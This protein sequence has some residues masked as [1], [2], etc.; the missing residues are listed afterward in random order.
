M[1]FVIREDMKRH[2]L[3]QFLALAALIS[4]LAASEAPTPL[5]RVHAHNDYMHTRPLLDA[6]DHG[7]CSVE[8]DIYLVDG[9]L[10]VAHDRNK[11]DPQRTLQSLYLEPL[12]QRIKANGGRLYRNGPPSWLLI[13]VKSDAEPTFAALHEVLRSYADILTEFRQ[14]E[15]KTNA[16]TVVISGNRSRPAL[17]AQAVRYATYDGRLADL[18]A[19]EP[20]D[21]IPWISDNWAL[22]FKWRG[23]GPISTAEQAKLHDIL[24]QAHRKG[25]L[26]RFWGAPDRAEVWEAFY[27]A[28]VDLLNTDDLGGMQKFLLE[29][30][31]KN[32]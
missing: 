5:T 27:A 28:G 18:S 6:L 23:Q 1:K 11:V 14:G 4:T 26:V 32:P 8:A 13:D 17:A 22:F 7:F 25:R 19:P 12:R 31:N 10:L 3:I 21:F 2:Y 15:V 30:G 16:I 20:S 24:D 9:Q 29:K